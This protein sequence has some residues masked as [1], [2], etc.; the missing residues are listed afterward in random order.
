MK[1]SKN[2]LNILKNYAKINS[3]LYIFAGN[4]IATW[5]KERNQFSD[6]VVE[7]NFPVDFGIVD[8]PRFLASVS[9]YNDPEFTFGK[10]CVRFGEG[11]ST[12][13]Y[14]YGEPMLFDM[15]QAKKRI[16]MPE[17]P[18]QF[19]LSADQL[20]SIYKSA[21]VLQAPNLSI[22]SDND[23][24]IVRVHDITV[25]TSSKYTVREFGSAKGHTINLNFAVEFMSM[26]LDD[27]TVSLSER[28]VQFESKNMD[29]RYFYACLG[30]STLVAP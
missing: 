30:G 29:L 11:S 9:M 6:A 14:Y 17:T 24:V 21:S 22:L 8:L 10:D 3:K 20:A 12:T 28:I 23:E 27:Y 7:D 18:I 13:T 25:E 2:T 4:S 26:I 1:I 16:R 19:D 5:T 15:T